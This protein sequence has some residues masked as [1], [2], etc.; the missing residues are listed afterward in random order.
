MLKYVVGETTLAMGVKN[1]FQSLD[2]WIRIC[3]RSYFEKKK[4]VENQNKRV[5]TPLL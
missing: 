4:A 3:V 1:L 5:P 2:E